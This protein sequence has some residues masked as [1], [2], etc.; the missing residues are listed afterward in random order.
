MFQHKQDKKSGRYLCDENNPMPKDSPSWARW[1]HPKAK[2]V[3]EN[4]EGDADDFECPI[5]K[6]KWRTY[7]DD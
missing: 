3:G 6:S 2:C 1:V 7:Y 4:Y 5:C